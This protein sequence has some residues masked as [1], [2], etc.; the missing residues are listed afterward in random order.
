[1]ISVKF[2]EIN[3]NKQRKY[4]EAINKMNICQIECTC[5]HCGCL[6]RH[7]YYKRKVK[8]KDETITLYILRV[9][10]KEC[11]KTHAI[12]PDMIIPYS[13]IP[14]DI[15]HKIIKGDKAEYINEITNPDI[16]ESDIYRIRMNYR[17]H[18]KERIKSIFLTIEDKIEVIIEG[19]YKYFGKLFMQIKRCLI[20]K[21]F[22]ST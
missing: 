14:A 8:T 4:N 6:V 13:Q 10:C 18:W 2:S 16:V 20:K 1:M 3:I 5:G 12:L 22:V 21:F 15:Q 9:K 11:R 19:C 17:K 7:G